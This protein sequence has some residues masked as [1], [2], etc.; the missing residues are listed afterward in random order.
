MIYPTRGIVLKHFKYAETSIVVH[1]YT[2]LFGRQVYILNGVRSAKNKGKTVFLQ[3]LSHLSLMVYHNPKKEI[4]RISE[5]R[6]ETPLSSIPF[7]QHKRH[8]AF[9][10]TEVLHLV[11]NEAEPNLSLFEFIAQSINHFD[12][13]TEDVNSFHLHFLAHLT[14]HLGFYPD[15]LPSESLNF[16]DLLNGIACDHEPIHNYFIAK[17]EALSWQRLFSLDIPECYHQNIPP[18]ERKKL[19]NSL[20]EYYSLHI[21]GFGHLKSLEVLSSLNG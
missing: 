11:L 4:Q 2:E 10:I 19:L 3:P 9:F 6:T 18:N 15:L 12:R 5:F 14:R 7:H 21:E 20:M 8:I 1:V 13:Q 17:E 16:F